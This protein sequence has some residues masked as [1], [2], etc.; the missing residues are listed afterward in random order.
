MTMTT[1]TKPAPRV[2]THD[3]LMAELDRFCAIYGY[4]ALPAGDLWHM[5]MRRFE[6]L[7]D[8]DAYQDAA[9]LDRFLRRWARAVGE[10]A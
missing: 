2:D 1:E 8:P 9:Y 3:S 5:A 4:P 10:E 7:G 6:D